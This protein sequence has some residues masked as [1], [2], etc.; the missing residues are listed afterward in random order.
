VQQSRGMK[1]YMWA[2]YV[3]FYWLL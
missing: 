1:L 2:L 3:N